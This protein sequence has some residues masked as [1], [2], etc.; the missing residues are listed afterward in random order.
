RLR[1][2]K[3]FTLHH[4]VHSLV[5][6]RRHN[7]APLR[8]LHV[9]TQRPPNFAIPLLQPIGSGSQLF[10]GGRRFSQRLANRLESRFHLVGSMH[11]PR[12]RSIEASHLAQEL[13]LRHSIRRIHSCRA[14]GHYLERLRP[15]HFRHRAANFLKHSH[16]IISRQHQGSLIRRLRKIL[17]TFVRFL[18][19]LRRRISQIPRHPLKP[20]LRAAIHP[21]D[22]RPS[23]VV[24]HEINLR[25]RLLR[26]SP[27]FVVRRIGKRLIFL[28]RVL[29]RVLP[30]LLPGLNLLL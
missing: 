14:L 4:R 10:F 13:F 28:R 3:P 26:L 27:Q 21:P 20:S 15:G 22:R 30:R 7:L 6:R 8:D 23:L 29:L 9:A 2:R 16:R 18:L 17:F 25:F 24:H 12:D 5:D 1:Q 19:D 11:R